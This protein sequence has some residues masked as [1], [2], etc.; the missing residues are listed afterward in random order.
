MPLM[1]DQLPLREPNPQD[2]LSVQTVTAMLG[3]TVATLYRYVDDGKIRRYRPVGAT[4]SQGPMFWLPEIEVF[5]LA[6]RVA[7]GEV[8]ADA[9]A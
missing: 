3:I 6:R 9:R 4:G 1:I 8:K 5:A 2:W 7:R